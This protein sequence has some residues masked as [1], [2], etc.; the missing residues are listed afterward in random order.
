MSEL[1]ISYTD[2]LFLLILSDVIVLLYSQG[3]CS[4]FSIA[5][6]INNP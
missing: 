2:S 6:C 5:K 1:I 3:L 4:H